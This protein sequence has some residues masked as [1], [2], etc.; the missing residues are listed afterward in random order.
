MIGVSH[1]A[2]PIEIVSAINEFVS[3]PPK[4]RIFSKKVDNWIDRSLPAGA[5][6]GRQLEREF[7]WEWSQAQFEDGSAAVGVFS[8]DRSLAIYPFY[9]VLGCLENSAPVTILLS[10]NMLSAGDIPTFPQGEF[11]NVMEGVQHIIPPK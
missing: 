10:F 1:D 11:Q 4:K 5:L 9:F 7:D 2:P 3:N 8:P 6:W